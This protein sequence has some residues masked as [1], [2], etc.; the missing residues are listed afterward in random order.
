MVLTRGV[1]DLTRVEIHL[2]WSTHLCLRLLL[3]DGCECSGCTP[4]VFRTGFLCR[5]RDRH[6]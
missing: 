5:T 6:S 4:L 1:S 3:A 2:L